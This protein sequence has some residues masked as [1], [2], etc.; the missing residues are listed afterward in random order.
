MNQLMTFQLN[1]RLIVG[2][3]T[4]QRTGEQA[5]ASGVHHP[6]IIT[7]P[8]MVSTGWVA[9]LVQSLHSAGLEVSLFTDVESDPGM[10]TI[11]RAAQVYQHENCDGIIAFGGGSPMDCAKAAAVLVSNP[12]ELKDYFGIGKVTQPL[13]VLFAIPTTVGTGSE[14]TT[15]AVIS[16]LDKHK[17]MVI[18][19]PLIA[20]HTAILDPEVV[21]TLPERIVA[22]TGIDALAHAIE[23]ILSVF[24]TPFSDALALEAVSLVQKNIKQAVCSHDPA[25][26][27]QLLY[28]ST[29]A[30]Y[31]FSNAR[32]GLVHGMAH[33]IGSYHHVHHGLAIAILLPTVMDFNLPYC[34]EKL[35]RIANAMGGPARAEAAVLIVRSLNAEVGIPARLSVA[36]VTSEY[37][38]VM[39]R[40]A[41]ESG[42]AQVVNP[43]KPTYSE[44]LELYQQA[45]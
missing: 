13:P 26:R 19:S 21:A 18:G 5:L 33:P 24:A 25:A 14:V 36:G 42:N 23:S 44:V 15:F 22:A 38:E 30:G 1:T 9:S 20:P 4:L 32:T 40:D 39:A 3:G 16:D 35:A 45:L 11:V 29:L 34:S 28:A 2:E 43:R 7:D 10:D 8:G 17:K 12:G 31:A 41:F 27:A 6:L 37:F